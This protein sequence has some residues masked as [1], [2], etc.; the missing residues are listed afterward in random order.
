MERITLTKYGFIRSKEDDFSDDGNRF[1]CYKV[2]KVRVSKL[3]SD[4]EAYIDAYIDCGMLPYDIY[5]KLPHYKDMSV[6]NGVSVSS[7]TEDD[8]QKLYEDC[9][10]YEKEY[11]DAYNAI[12]WP[13][14]K[15]IADKASEFFAD[16]IKVYNQLE[17]E[18]RYNML[19]IANRCSSYEWSSLR[20]YI[21]SFRNAYEQYSDP[22]DYGRRLFKNV[23]SLEFVKKTPNVENNFWAKQ[24]RKIIEQYSD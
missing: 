24:I 21:R 1:T 15:E 14:E 23:T 20:D 3:V 12:N 17:E 10:S 8:L 2:G 22:D 19:T 6:L 5:S 9:I 13:S 7:I 16:Y 11:D 18:L 4:G